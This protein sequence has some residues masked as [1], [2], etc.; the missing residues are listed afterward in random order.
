[1]AKA[2]L[3]RAAAAGQEIARFR[4][5]LRIVVE[6]DFAG[7]GRRAALDLVEQARPGSI[8]VKT[9]RAGAQ[10]KRPLQRVQGAKHRAGAGERAE[11]VAGQAARAAM[12]DQPR[13][14]MIGADQDIGEA[15]VVAQRDVVAGL[16]LLDEIG[17]EQQRLGVRLGGDEHHRVGLRDHARDAA[18]LA[19][20]RHIGGD[21][22]LDRARLADI[23]HLALGPD[24]AIDAGPE[25]RMAPEGADRLGAARERAQAQPAAR[26]GRCRGERNRAQ[27]RA[28]ARLLPAPRPRAL[29][30]EER[31]SMRRSW[32]PYLGASG[33]GGNRP[34]A[35]RLPAFPLGVG[36]APGLAVILP[37]RPNCFQALRP[38]LV[39]V[40]NESPCES[41][42]V[43][44][45]GRRYGQQFVIQ[46]R[47]LYSMLGAVESAS[48]RR[49]A[50]W[51]GVPASC[52]R[53]R[54]NGL[55]TLPRGGGRAAGGVGSSVS[56]TDQEP[57]QG[58]CRGSSF[59]CWRARA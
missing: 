33:C 47:V 26:R 44:N 32:G 42:T 19:L 15:L 30:R 34:A 23:E 48:A 55:L 11:I 27:A 36:G 21:A 18:R 46:R 35:A 53:G 25:R 28:R 29:R 40:L 37:A 43:A 8:G 22:L 1:M 3:D 7:A 45:R 20:G 54:L 59:C 39:P 10:E 5:Q 31:C 14:R 57:G 52:W 58:A 4:H 50:G 16:Q 49:R 38:L 24:H 17:L 13:R 6:R 2:A 51:R 41:R 9:V 56:F 12:L